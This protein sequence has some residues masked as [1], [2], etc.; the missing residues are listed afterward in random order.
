M[1]AVLKFIGTQT[2]SVIIC[3]TPE[4]N[5]ERENLRELAEFTG[6]VCIINHRGFQYMNPETEFLVQPMPSSD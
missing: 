3:L 1:K 4:S 2:N 5:A 6:R